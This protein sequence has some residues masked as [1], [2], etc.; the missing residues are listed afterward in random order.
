M[1][2]IDCREVM[3]RTGLSR[4]TLWRLERARAFPP[5]RRLTS[6]RVG[7]IENEIEEWLRSR[8]LGLTQNGEIRGMSG[9]ARGFA[10]GGAARRLKE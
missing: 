10:A 1:R 8:P 6:N 2:M 5:R 9:S 3:D 4:T 7:W